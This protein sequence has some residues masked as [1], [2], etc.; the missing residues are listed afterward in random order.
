MT[1]VKYCKLV[2]AAIVSSGT[3]LSA[4]TV[5]AADTPASSKCSDIK[6]NADLLKKYPNAPAGCQDIVVKDGMK[7]A[8]FD[9]TVIAVHPDG[10]SV[11]FVD[12]YGNPGRVMKIQPGKDA[13][14]D[15][16]GEK[17]AYAKL[18]KDQKMTFYIPESTLGVISDPTDSASSTIVVK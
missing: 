13:T 7:F 8:R 15:V 16:A 4:A 6:W 11:R 2:A 5:T 9:A 1:M 10:V 14:V 17:V 18:K 3:L 12:P